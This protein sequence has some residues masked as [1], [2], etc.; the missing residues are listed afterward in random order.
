MLK[1]FYNTIFERI[2]KPT[3]IIEDK[4]SYT[5]FSPIELPKGYDIHHSN[6]RYPTTICKPG[7]LKP[8]CIIVLYGGM[9]D[10]LAQILNK[11]IV[12]EI[13]PLLIIPTSLSHPNIQ[14]IIDSLEITNNI[15]FGGRRQ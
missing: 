8:N 3:I 2:E 15:I 12:N 4:I 10:E 7:K 1:R 14:P 5:K 9:V 6:D 11:L 13:I